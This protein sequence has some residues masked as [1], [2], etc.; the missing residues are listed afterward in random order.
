MKKTILIAII[1]LLVIVFGVWKITSYYSSDNTPSDSSSPLPTNSIS[2]SPTSLDQ[3]TP[4][5][6]E[7]LINGGHLKYTP[8]PYSQLTKP[9]TCKVEGSIEFVKSNTYITKGAKISWTGIDNPARQIK[10]KI[11]P[12]DNLRIGPNLMA[13]LPIP[14]G[15][16][17]VGATLPEN[18][19]SR[20]YSLTASITY[21]RL[22]DGNPKDY[23]AS[24]SGKVTVDLNY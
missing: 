17:E 24:C 1:I 21:S 19:K 3:L 8:V 14:D 16:N 22:V 6:V 13:N 20:H 9:A 12:S 15:S 4:Q 7:N 18:P 23:E 10:W 2:P 11:S 5:E